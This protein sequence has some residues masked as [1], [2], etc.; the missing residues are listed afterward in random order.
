MVGSITN[1]I[2]PI[3]TRAVS[4]VGQVEGRLRRLHRLS[5]EKQ[6][7]VRYKVFKNATRSS[8]SWAV[9]PMWKR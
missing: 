6:R 9:N 5:T 8:F 7:R 4:S 3:I 1:E 2:N